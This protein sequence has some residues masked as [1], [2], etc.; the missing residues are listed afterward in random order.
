MFSHTSS[1]IHSDTMDA[2]TKSTG[3]IAYTF[4]YKIPHEHK[5]P[6]HSICSSEI[7]HT[8]Q[9]KSAL[10]KQIDQ[11]IYPCTF[12]CISHLPN[13]TCQQ[14]RPLISSNPLSSS[15]FS[16]KSP[17]SFLSI[18]LSQLSSM[19]IYTFPTKISHTPLDLQLL[20]SRPKTPLLQTSS[21]SSY[22]LLY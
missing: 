10:Q 2:Y 16:P 17:R 6:H 22:Q 18:Y 15:A 12:L 13:F 20:S 5:L 11:A 8:T 3:V 7:K 1:D 14:H 9:P 4:I 21:F 19:L